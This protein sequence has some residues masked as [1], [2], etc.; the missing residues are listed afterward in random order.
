MRTFSVAIAAIALS[1]GSAYAWSPQNC[2][3]KCR[4]T[5]APDKVQ[6]CQTSNGGCARFAGGKHESE[7]HVRDSAARWKARSKGYLAGSM[8]DG[9]MSGGRT[10]RNRLGA[11]PARA[12]SAGYC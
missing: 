10:F 12:H 7:A 4:L 1:V 6:L 8:Y 2:M 9:K 11:C 5:A 3:L